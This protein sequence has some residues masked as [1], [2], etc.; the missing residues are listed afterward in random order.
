MSIASASSLDFDRLD[1][2]ANASAPVAADEHVLELVEHAAQVPGGLRAIVERYVAAPNVLVPRAVSF[3]LAQQAAAP[4]AETWELTRLPAARLRENDDPSTLINGLTAV[5]R[6]VIAGHPLPRVPAAAP[7]LADFLLH[8]LGQ[9]PLI[10]STASEVLVRLDED[11]LL[12]QLFP[13]PQADLLRR[14]LTDAP[15]AGPLDQQE[16]L[17]RLLAS[18]NGR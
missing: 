18:L 1:E 10:R 6:H 2:I 15:A 5:Q 13:P 16:D 8:C 14:A 9:A 3:V 17:D 4:T 7:D 11:R 12:A